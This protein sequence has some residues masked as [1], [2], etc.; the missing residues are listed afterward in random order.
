MP[1]T[2]S[3]SLRSVEADSF[4]RSLWGLLL[5]AIFLVA[6]C[7]WFSCAKV[8]VHETTDHA[9][10]EVERAAHPVAA[11]VAGRILASH[12]KLGGHVQ[13]G[14]VLVEL[15]SEQERLQLEEE[16][17]RLSTLQQRRQA[18]RNQLAAEEKAWPE[19]KKTAL[20]AIDEARARQRE[21]E[22]AAK[23]AEAEAARLKNLD[24]NGLIS[25]SEL[26]RTETEAQKQRESA[27]AQA[28]TVA[29][30]ESDVT[31][32]EKNREVRLAQLQ[33][34]AALLDGDIG[35][36]EA[37][38]KRNEFAV[39][40]RRI[41]A[42]IGGE[43]GELAEL[44]AGS[45]VAEGQRLAAIIPPGDLKLVA[46]F[47]PLTAAGRIHPGQPARMR[48]TGFPWAQYGSVQATVTGVANEP[49]EG[50]LRVELSVRPESVPNVP[51]QH[52]LSGTVEVQVDRLSPA[53]LV[54][55]AAGKLL[56]VPRIRASQSASRK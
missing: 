17:T 31:S 23:F 1:T 24:A 30:L 20:L 48:L 35:T 10:L 25:K 42:P 19:E 33:R 41:R 36:S 3:R 39:E 18:L 46:Q 28:A 6:G 29:R 44:R 50:Q 53:T 51:L 27:S 45:V 26:L 9:R 16:K 21:A 5:V 54:L 32:R 38:V 4:R 8:A 34:D 7:I 52:G 14:E 15:E 40:Q 12:L 49:L 37:A 2:F 22:A 13:A 56:G 11:P 47:S 55:R 43:I